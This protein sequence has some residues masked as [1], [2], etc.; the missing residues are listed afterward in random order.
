MNL[1]INAQSGT[2][3]CETCPSFLGSAEASL[4]FK[5]GT[6]AP[7][8]ARFGYLLGKPGLAPAAQSKITESYAASCSKHGEPRPTSIT[9]L[10]TYVTGPDPEVMLNGMPQEWERIKVTNC[11]TCKNFVKP[12]VVLEEFGWVG[13]LCAQSG[14]L[15]LQNRFTREAE[16]CSWRAPGEARES[17]TGLH[18][19]PVYQNA[20]SMDA[21][22]NPMSAFMNGEAPEIIEPNDW[23]TEKDVSD[24]DR[25]AGIR[26]FRKITD[27][28]GSGNFTFLPVYDLDHFVESDLVLIPRTGDDE[29]PELYV[30]HSGA[31]YD[32]AVAW[33]ELDETPMAWGEPGVGKTELYRHIAWMMQVPFRR[34]SITESSEVDDIIGKPQYD[35][36]RGTFF[37]Y[38]RLPKAWQSPGVLVIDEPNVGP[39]AVWQ[40]I[41]PLT[42]NSKQLVIDQ[43]EGERIDRHVDCFLGMAANP[44][45]DVRNVGANQIADADGRRLFHLTL[46]LPPAQ[47]ER[48]IMRERCRLDGWEIDEK[49]LD[50]IM[51]NATDIRNLAKDGTIPISWGIAQQIKVA[52]A[53]RWFDMVTAYRRAVTDMLEPETADQILDFVRS[54][55]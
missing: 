41:R 52:R 19:K 10:T 45:W 39:Q 47:V 30:D 48:H 25:A 54:N 29:H 24:E 12:E 3:S 6:G 21:T 9:H 27:P 20:F 38:G 2:K 36:T 15:L 35:P 22:L 28:R 40:T 31:V 11:T 49:R 1:N 5:K 44:A 14:K 42:D 17:T 53:S 51:A 7:M 8:C 46:P 26:A 13:G 18:L 55:G 37:V 43:N 32:C 34:L 33:M 4:F 16:S 23:V 50:V